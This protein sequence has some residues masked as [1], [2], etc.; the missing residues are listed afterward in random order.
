MD[1]SKTPEAI[2]LTLNDF[3][4]F[5]NGSENL[6]YRLP[7]SATESTATVIINDRENC[8]PILVQINQSSEIADC[9]RIVY[10]SSRSLANPDSDSDKPKT[11]QYWLTDEKNDCPR[12]T[13][14]LCA[15]E[16]QFCRIMVVTDYFLDDKDYDSSAAEEK[17]RKVTQKQAEQLAESFASV[18]PLVTEIFGT[19]KT[20]DWAASKQNNPY[21]ITVEDDDRI[22]ILL[23]CFDD[24]SKSG[25]STVGFF[26]PTD[27]LKNY[28]GG[29]T[30]SNSRA[31]FYADSSSLNKHP[32]QMLSILV[33][34]FQHLLNTVHQQSNET[35][36][37]WYQEMM[38][39]QA[40][41][42]MTEFFKENVPGFDESVHSP[43]S[44]IPFINELY[45]FVG[46]GEWR[47]NAPPDSE[48]ELLPLQTCSYAQL[49]CFGS[50]LARNYG[51]AKLIQTMAKSGRVNED[52][53]NYA[54]KELGFHQNFQ[55]VVEEYILSFGQKR[56][57]SGTLLKSADN[58]G[59]SAQY[60]QA[61]GTTGIYSFPQNPVSLWIEV[62][63]DDDSGE[64][65][66][67]YAPS[68]YLE[69]VTD[70]IRPYG[71]L[72]DGLKIRAD[73]SIIFNLQMPGNS[74]VEYFILMIR[75][76]P[77]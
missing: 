45:P 14:A 40:E 29:N 1:K 33:H 49:Y 6:F 11:E 48:D 73:N 41:D 26:R 44:R 4:D 70:T 62:P 36:E 74:S 63:K 76:S 23:Y 31:M 68:Y 52:A 75:P 7:S 20:S 47:N 15:A 27:I 50:F 42:L 71:F 10:D 43:K 57:T 69:P 17:L 12:L 77:Q 51:G 66:I 34:E 58:H 35:V 22:D 32:E 8:V 72:M 37:V 53:I 64:N 18:Y 3:S 54:L 5:E 67:L 59:I 60:T 61:D 13:K 56:A 28:I 21:F 46:I 9:A 25:S 65:L 19:E 24:F 38:S 2:I 16:N 39:M 30:I 55:G